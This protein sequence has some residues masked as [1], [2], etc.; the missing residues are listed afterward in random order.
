MFHETNLSITVPRS[1][2][3]VL[4]LVAIGYGCTG[5]PQA[6]ISPGSLIGIPTGEPCGLELDARRGSI[7][8][9]ATLRVPANNRSTRRGTRGGPYGRVGSLCGPT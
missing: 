2:V 5:E 3:I 7:S 9:E 4:L 8:E 6:E 1:V